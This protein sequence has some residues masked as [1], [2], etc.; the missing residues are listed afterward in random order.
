MSELDI[1]NIGLKVGLEIHQQLDTKKKL[2]CD[3]TPIEEEEFSM[4]FSRKL[5]AAKSELGKID[6][7]ALFE[8][9][10]S[11]TIVYY[12][13][14]K[15]SCLVEEDEE[16]PHALDTDAK[17]IVLLISSALESKIFSEIHVMR[18]T[19]IDGS[20][21]TGFQRTMLVAQGGH[22]EVNGKKVG[23]Q[24]ICLEEDAGKLI[25]DEGNHR[26]F[27]LDRLGVPLI[28]IALDPVEGDAKFVKDI[29]LTLG[30]L[31]RVTKKVMRGIGT[32]RQDVN[33]SVEGGGVIEVKGV[34]QLDQLEKIIE[35]EAKR[36][37]GLK[38]ISEKINQTKFSEID[39]RKDVF[40]ITEIMQECN[41]NII[42][43]S[44]EKQDKIFGIRIKKLK[45][46]LGFEPYS[47]IRLGK[48]IGQL[49]RFFGIGGVFHSDELPNYGIE[50][51]DIKR[52][53]EKLDIQNEDAFLIIAGGRNSVG[54]AIDSII[55]RI[56][57][58]KNGPPAETRAATPNGDTIFLRPRP[59][60]SRMYPET[61]IPT[62]KVTDDE[63]IKV[64]SNIPK[65]WEDSIKE[66]EEKYRI[67]NQLAEQI[68]DSE[69]FEIFE[70]ICSQK[71]NS[72]NFV[73]S[74]L[75]S[76]ITNLERS[77]LNSSLLSNEHIKKTFEL[78]EQEKIN[79][80]SI[81]IIF[82]QIMSK[83]ANGVLQAL[84]NASISQLT[85]DELDEILNKIIQ[86][87]IDKIKQ[88]QMRAL[89]GIMGIA[90][91]E[92]RGKA[93]GKIIN[94]KLKEKIQNFLN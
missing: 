92:V 70:Q 66:L 18:K 1:K 42:K 11:K 47:D 43:K 90:M 61:D 15:S 64:R 93:S 27:S 8:S 48:E 55:N 38:L 81:Q 50:N 3:C 59:G 56:K 30:R 36:Q 75:C 39:R 83:K 2:F 87:N 67:N 28:E 26:F 32:I 62:V 94:Q 86:E 20:N 88:E 74:I 54:F 79:K 24:S 68:F 4:K 84:E 31:L 51:A 72:P 37:H 58:S 34:Q 52:V 25:K 33:I 10:K 85:E 49:V 77:G 19:V 45:G 78:L 40:D 9:T 41:S 46:I 5:R 65:S 23:V 57:L 76:T 44:I 63:L 29:A 35:F 60:A 80:E 89:S 71:Q 6:P 22:I 16:P 21:T 13:N 7:A 73:V 17:N 82:E 91:K 69:Y 12:A 14:P 53:T